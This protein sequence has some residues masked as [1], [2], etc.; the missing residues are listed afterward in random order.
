MKKGDTVFFSCNGGKFFVIAEHSGK[1]YVESETWILKELAVTT[2]APIIKYCVEKRGRK[3][4]KVMDN[5]YITN[6][7]KFLSVKRIAGLCRILLIEREY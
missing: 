2:R 1:H 6:H 5:K 3:V 7:V 4:P